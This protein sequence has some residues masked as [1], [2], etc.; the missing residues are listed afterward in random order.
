V[1]YLLKIT[2]RGLI[3]QIHSSYLKTPE[4]QTAQLCRNNSDKLEDCTCSLTVSCH[5]KRKW[6]GLMELITCSAPANDE[7]D[8]SEVQQANS[9]ILSDL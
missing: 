2:P 8:V 6:A 7:C 4:F 1:I 9:S 3:R 5:S